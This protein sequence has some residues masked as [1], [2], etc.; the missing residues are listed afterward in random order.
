MLDAL[1]NASTEPGAIT[2]S[3]TPTDDSSATNAAG[4]DNTGSSTA[5]S[6][7]SATT[8]TGSMASNSGTAAAGREEMTYDQIFAHQQVQAHEEGVALF[9]A[10]AQNGDNPKLQ[11]FARKS[12]PTLQEHLKMAQELVE[13]QNK[14]KQD[15]QSQTQQ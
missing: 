2:S 15:N 11:E 4:A 13:A 9:E 5:N 1:N 10:Y 14:L 7:S 6:G 12:L 8:T 3:T